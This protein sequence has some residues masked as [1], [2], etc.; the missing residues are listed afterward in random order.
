MHMAQIA[1]YNVYRCSLCGRLM[2]NRNGLM[3]HFQQAHLVQLEEKDVVEYR[4]RMGDST[5]GELPKIPAKRP[6]PQAA[7]KANAA[8]FPF[9]SV[10]APPNGTVEILCP[11]CKIP[12]PDEE[13]MRSHYVTAHL[14]SGELAQAMANLEK[15]QVC[16][17]CFQ[18]FNE[19][20]AL[21]EHGIA[22]L[23]M[24]RSICLL[25]KNI[26]VPPNSLDKHLR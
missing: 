19:Q 24:G 23:K 8:Q 20:R 4:I 6:H 15:V 1:P 25:C 21:V 11:Y 14:P 9:P 10:S 2:E 5:P 17:S 3:R 13:K 16:L 26:N 12:I 18:C 7:N 22:H